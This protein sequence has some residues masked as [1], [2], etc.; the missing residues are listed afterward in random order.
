MSEKWD[1]SLFYLKRLE[2]IR[3]IPKIFTLRP[4]KLEEKGVGRN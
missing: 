3:I 4:N 1:Q 2:V